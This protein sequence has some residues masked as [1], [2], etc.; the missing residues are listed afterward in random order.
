MCRILNFRAVFDSN[1]TPAT[2]S[3]EPVARKFQSTILLSET[4]P[5]RNFQASESNHTDHN[6]DFPIEGLD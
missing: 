5:N 6:F 2:V 1:E 4:K 3:F